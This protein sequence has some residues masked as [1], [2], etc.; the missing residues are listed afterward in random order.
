[1]ETEETKQIKVA[2]AKH[3]KALIRHGVQE[4]TIG[5]ITGGKGY[6]RCD[7][8]EFDNN[9]NFYAYEIKVSVSDLNSNNKLSYCANKNYL[10]VNQTVYDWLFKTNNNGQREINHEFNSGGF[11]II[12]YQ[13]D[14]VDKLQ[15]VTR[16]SN[17]QL[18]LGERMELL[19]AI[20]KSA[21]RDASKLL[22]GD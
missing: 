2:L 8:V 15:S 7:Y 13:P 5:H 22:T 18:G 20:A 19:E 3:S 10:V 16:C 4:V 9:M 14:S 6:D 12:L 21:C 11:G 1:M 17:Q